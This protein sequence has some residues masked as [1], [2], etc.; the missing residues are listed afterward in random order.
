MWQESED[1]IGDLLAS[2]VLGRA[3]QIDDPVKVSSWW[4][5]RGVTIASAELNRDGLF[6]LADECRQSSDR[7]WVSFLWLSLIHI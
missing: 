1:A 6:R 7:D 3:D 2:V 5:N 4:A